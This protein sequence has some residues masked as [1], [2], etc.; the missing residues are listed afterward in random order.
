MVLFSKNRNARFGA[1]RLGQAVPQNAQSVM[2]QPQFQLE[3]NLQNETAQ[4]QAE[5]VINRLN[6]S[7]ILPGSTTLD[8]LQTYGLDQDVGIQDNGE[9]VVALTRQAANPAQETQALIA[10]PSPQVMAPVVQPAAECEFPAQ[11]VNFQR[12]VA[13][14]NTPPQ[15]TNIDTDVCGNVVSFTEE[16]VRTMSAS[17]WVATNPSQ[18]VQGVNGVGNITNVNGVYEFDNNPNV[19]VANSLS[20]VPGGQVTTAQRMGAYRTA[21]RNASYGAAAMRKW[22]GA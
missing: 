10:M 3:G 17:P 12:Q 9:A 18:L 15:I 6:H 11:S 4:Q 2:Q 8:D 1:R 14:T 7:T 22:R 16:M 5:D 13:I 21:N 19:R 20:Q